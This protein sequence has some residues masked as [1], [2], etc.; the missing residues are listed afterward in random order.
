MKQLM[1]HA[2]WIGV[3]AEEGAV[4]VVMCVLTVKRLARQE[5]VPS[6]ACTVK[7]TRLRLIGCMLSFF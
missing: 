5:A 4:L 6:G 1:L 2:I 7:S 3:C